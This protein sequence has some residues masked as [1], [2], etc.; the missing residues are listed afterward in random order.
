MDEFDKFCGDENENT[1]LFI[2]DFFDQGGV[3]FSVLSKVV[4]CF[5][6]F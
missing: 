6:S 5:Q 3:L 2:I 1:K 4:S